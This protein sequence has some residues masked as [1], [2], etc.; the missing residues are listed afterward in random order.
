MKK[1]KKWIAVLC[2][3]SLIAPLST[4]A[5][6]GEEADTAEMAVEETGQSVSKTGLA[7]EIA[8]YDFLRDELGLN[9]AAICGILANI[10]YE[11]FFDEKAYNPNDTGGTVSYGLFQWNNGAGAGNRYGQLQEWCQANGY[12]Y[13]S[14]DGQL[15]F[16][17]YELT[18]VYPT[19]FR[20]SYLQKNI[21]NTADGAYEAAKIWAK[22]YEGCSKVSHEG[23]ANLAKNEYWTAYLAHEDNSITISGEK[24]PTALMLGQGC[25]IQGTI[26]SAQA[27]AEVKV[28]VYDGKDVY[29]IG[30]SK[31]F[32]A[33]D[34]ITSYDLKELDAEITFGKLTVGGYYYR[35]YATDVNGKTELLANDGFVVL[36][37]D[38]T[39]ADGTYKIYASQK[40]SYVL[41]IANSSHASGANVELDSKAA[42]VYQIFEVKH[43]G[44]GYYN[45]INLATGQYLDVYNSASVS[46][47]NVQQAPA[48]GNNSQK[49]Q[50]LPVG[51]AYCL[52]PACAT[53]LALDLEDGSV[54]KGTNVQLGNM[55]L[56]EGQKFGF[57]KTDLA[58]T[59]A[60]T[61]QLQSASGV[62]GKQ[63][64]VPITV[65]DNL[66]L[67]SLQVELFYDSTK[68][69]LVGVKEG[70]VLELTGLDTT[71]SSD[72]YTICWSAG[73]ETG[74]LSETGTMATAVFEI[75]NM[76]SNAETSITLT[77][78]KAV[79]IKG[80]EVTVATEDGKVTME[81]PEITERIPG[82]VNGDGVVRLNDALLLRRYVAGWDVEVDLS[83]SDVNGDGEVRL[84]DALLL[85]RY[86]AGWDVT[87]Q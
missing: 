35:V 68:L 54:V 14:L 65:K 58:A 76:A 8:I 43:I 4:Y 72:P 86:V 42:S 50:I 82:D 87:L 36:A 2:V 64:E 47:T 15:Y 18:K 61:L 80:Q 51:N 13:T 20:L 39:I 23:R 40:S 21:E 10:Q 25:T 46:G 45:I 41:D 83:A 57:T 66:G 32:N 44:N 71:Y 38:A 34:N 85:R 28:A 22:Y 56:W 55:S 19:Y 52:V 27:L 3:L 33:Q 75:L 69:K 9:T 17:K 53:A 67:A 48:N 12:D 7:N 31:S 26:T 74:N 5:T 63:V 37:N 73:S 70:D 11:S 78:K 1:N 30:A 77:C 16:M 79:N 24:A 60:G 84:N 49:W 29:Q 81:M 6:E 62:V 59:S